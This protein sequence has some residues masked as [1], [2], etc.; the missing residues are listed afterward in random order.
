MEG[1]ISGLLVLADPYLLA[2][3]VLP[4]KVGLSSVLCQDRTPIGAAFLLPFTL[5]LDPAQAIS[6]TTAIYCS[7]TF[8]AAITAILINT[9]GTAASATTCLDG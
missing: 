3:L 7:A 2:L 9:P 5:T 6:I 4:L 8:A 1:L